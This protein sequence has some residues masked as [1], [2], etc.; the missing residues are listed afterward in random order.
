MRNVDVN[1]VG[2]K[3]AEKGNARQLALH[4]H[5]ANFALVVRR[6][7]HEIGE[8]VE[9][10]EIAFGHVRRRPGLLEPIDGRRLERHDDRHQRVKR[11]QLVETFGDLDKVRDH[12][13]A[14]LDSFA[15]QYLA[16]TPEYGLVEASREVN[17]I[18]RFD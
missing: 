9:L 5:V 17:N 10:A 13:A 4:V 6:V 14:R 3:E 11:V 8:S 1:E 7:E 16:L 15:V 2:E 12:F 18:R